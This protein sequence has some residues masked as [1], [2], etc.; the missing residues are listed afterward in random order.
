MFD[1]TTPAA[2]LALLAATPTSDPTRAAALTW[3]GNGEELPATPIFCFEWD[4][5]KMGQLDTIRR[6]KQADEA[7]GWRALLGALGPPRQARADDAATLTGEA[8]LLELSTPQDD[9][10]LRVFTT[11]KEYDPTPEE[12]AKMRAAQTSIKAVIVTAT[13]DHDRIVP[14]GGP[15]ASAPILFTIAH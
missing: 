14:G 5:P 13:F 9:R 12:W 1:A 15:F 2:L 4:T 3:T 6:G 10:L 7:P 8:Y 11:G